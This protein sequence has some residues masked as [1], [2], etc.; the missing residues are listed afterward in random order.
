M[1]LNVLLFTQSVFSLQG[2]LQTN[3][4][5][6]A[7]PTYFNENNSD[8]ASC[9]FPLPAHE[10]FEYPG[11]PRAIGLWPMLEAAKA[12]W[13]LSSNNKFPTSLLLSA[14]TVIIIGLFPGYSVVLFS[15]SDY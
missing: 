14:V 3:N 9:P 4:K 7:L 11:T 13:Q 6:T 5:V 1:E 10:I 15:I 12:N 2:P 8:V